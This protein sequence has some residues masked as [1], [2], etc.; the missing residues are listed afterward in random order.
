MKEGDILTLVARSGLRAK[1]KM[2]EVVALRK[3]D[4]DRLME[5]IGRLS[6]MMIIVGIAAGFL[7]MFFLLQ[8]ERIINNNA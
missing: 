2:D 8:G 5:V 6:G 4:M 3:E 7:I 1:L